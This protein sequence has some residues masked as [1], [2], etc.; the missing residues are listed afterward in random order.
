MWTTSLQYYDHCSDRLKWIDHNTKPSIG[1][2]NVKSC[3][4][5]FISLQG[6]NP[7][8]VPAELQ[9]RI[10][11][12]NETFYKNQATITSPG[13]L[14]MLRQAIQSLHNYI[15]GQE[16]V[17]ASTSNDVKRVDR[18]LKRLKESNWKKNVKKIGHWRKVALQAALSSCSLNVV[19][20]LWPQAFRCHFTNIKNCRNSNGLLS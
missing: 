8:P 12:I 5:S 9:Q 20:Y 7:F 15:E 17:E 19:H 3:V 1:V 10:T 6:Q 13:S 11:R 4:E 18:L 16:L 2:K 14:N